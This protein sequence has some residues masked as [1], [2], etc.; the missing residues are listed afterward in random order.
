[1]FPVRLSIVTYNLWNTMRWPLRQPAVRQFVDLFRPDVLCVQELRPETRACLDDAM[2]QH[3][4][5]HDQLPGWA[6]ESN[7]YWHRGLFAESE[8]G[9]EDIGSLEEHRRL[10]WVRLK[11]AEQNRTIFVSTAHFTSQR[12]ATE[13]DLGQSPRIEQSRRTIAALQ[14][15]VRDNEP[16]WFMGDLNDAVHPTRML[17]EAGYSS[18]FAALGIQCPPTF[19]CYPTANVSAGARVINHTIDWLVANQ[20]ARAV[21]AQ[22]PQCYHG[23]VAP[24]DHWP[25]LAVYEI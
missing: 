5:V 16:A 24:S 1:M 22:V 10:F 3:T 8:H 23:D 17:H 15:L 20:H 6:C 7:I 14:R 2:S 4:R 13:T 19:P 21:A 12:Q 25:V 18:C 9:A 11:I